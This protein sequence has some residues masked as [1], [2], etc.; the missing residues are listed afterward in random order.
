MEN[1]SNCIVF[2]NVHEYMYRG[3]SKDFAD[4]LLEEWR[5][6][7]AGY[8]EVSILW[9]GKNKL[10]LAPK[11][12]DKALIEYHQIQFG[13]KLNVVT[14]QKFTS[15][16]ANDFLEDEH[17]IKTIEKFAK[18]CNPLHFVTWG[19]TQGAYALLEKIEN[20]TP[21]VAE[22]PKQSNFWTITEYDSKIGFKKLCKNLQLN[23]PKGYVCDSLN[24]A[25]NVI[26][27]FYSIQKGCVLKANWGA[28]GFG[29]I[30]IS[31]ALF[32]GSF[33][34]VEEYIRQNIVELPYFQSGQMLVE[35]FVETSKNS[36]HVDSDISSGFASAQILEDGSTKIIAAGIDIHG[37]NGYYEGARLGKGVFPKK[38]WNQIK[39]IMNLLGDEISRKGYKGHWGINYMLQKNGEIVLI[40][41]NT[42]RCGESHVHNIANCIAGESWMDTKYVL[43]RFPLDV[44]ITNTQIT[45]E[46]VLN[47]FDDLNSKEKE[48]LIVPVQLSWLKKV[49]F[50]GIGFMILGN[51]E[52]Q[53]NCA[54]MKLLNR[55]KEIG[56]EPL[57]QGVN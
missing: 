46:T 43:N 24:E 50:P 45:S 21:C 12:I 3:M 1:M 8:A 13:Y 48:T 53:V 23:V 25:L 44:K 27:K 33:N 41:M 20:Y 7:A 56:I 34:K 40:E 35:E 14:P 4:S 2:P 6:I 52:K 28:G 17:S 22:L 9:P 37:I 36:N 5:N 51:S 29:N 32:S 38:F 54:D 47:V 11:P 57:L 39:A 10:I 19:G 26:K 18:G 30:F 42:R 55:L 31:P 16:T 15:Q 49:R